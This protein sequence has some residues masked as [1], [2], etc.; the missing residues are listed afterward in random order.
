M[1]IFR[2]P[3]AADRHHHDVEQLIRP[4]LDQVAWSNHDLGVRG[5]NNLIICT[6][7]TYTLRRLKRDRHDLAEKVARHDTAARPGSPAR[8]QIGADRPPMS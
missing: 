5:L 2:T 8:R 4:A 3:D 1:A 7:A 6:G